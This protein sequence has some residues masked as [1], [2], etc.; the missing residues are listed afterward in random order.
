MDGM[1]LQYNVISSDTLRAAQK[2]PKSTR[3]SS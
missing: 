3:T 2:I 1:H